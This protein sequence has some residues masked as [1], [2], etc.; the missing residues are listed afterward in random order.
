MMEYTERLPTAVEL[1][2]LMVLSK[3]ISLFPIQN[4]KLHLTDRVFVPKRMVIW[5]LQAVMHFKVVI[6][7]AVQVWIQPAE[8]QVKEYIT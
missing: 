8:A 4:T 2:V 3:G 1:L 7:I 5:Q 6:G